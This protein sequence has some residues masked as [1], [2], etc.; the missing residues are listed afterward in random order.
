MKLGIR[1]KFIGILAIASLLPL[2]FAIVAVLTVG[3]SH[4]RK[5]RGVMFASAASYSART[6]R[7]LSQKQV[8]DI[9]DLIAL[10]DLHHMAEEVNQSHAA[11]ESVAV[12]ARMEAMEARWPKL[13]AHDPE[14]RRYLES[15]I[16]RSLR[17]FQAL[18]PV[19]KELFV[20]DALGGLTGTTAKTSDFVQ[21]DEKWW[22]EAAKLKTG[23]AWLDELHFDDSAGVF[24]LD[25]CV[26]IRPPEKL[27]GPISGVLKA[28]LN[29]SALF[30][31]VVTVGASEDM[32]TEVVLGDGHV[33][34]RML[35]RK[36]EPRAEKFAGATL[37]RIRDNR[38]GWLIGDLGTLGVQMVGFAPLKLNG[39]FS[40]DVSGSSAAQM[41]VTVRQPAGVVLAPVR[42]QV[43]L[44]TLAGIGLT[45]AFAFVGLFIARKHILEP[46]DVVKSAARTIAAGVRLAGETPADPGTTAGRF[47]GSSAAASVT[48]SL[49]SVRT[50]DELE[51]MARDF[52]R[53]ATKVLHYQDQ[54]EDDIAAKTREIQSDLA[55]ARE[56][57]EALLPRAYP[58]V[59]PEGEPDPVR[60]QFNHVYQPTLAMSGDFF[61]VIKVSDHKA[62][63]LIADVMGHGARSALVTAILRTLLQD[64]SAEA[65][66][67]ARML[68][69]LNQHFH[70]IIGRAK[71]VL[72]VSVSYIVID[73][74]SSEAVFA[75]AGHPSPLVANRNTGSVDP[76]FERLKNN[77]ALGLFPQ[78]HYTSMTRHVRP[79]DVFVLFTDGITEAP[80]ADGEE[81]GRER[82]MELISRNLNEDGAKFP[83][84]IVDG[85]H[86]FAGGTE[87]P[88]DVCLVTVEVMP[89]TNAESRERAFDS[90]EL[91]G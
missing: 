5:E 87:L 76:L 82:L 37:E 17:E 14:F 62:G 59:P 68:E 3:Y 46:L 84:R 48:Q 88:D 20:T 32:V 33:L 65:G 12:Q 9:N 36:F 28:V 52:G 39:V 66:D 31:Q 56:F 35:D 69:L 53:M 38:T 29:V 13:A 79:G 23:Q 22:Q 75:S 73:T 41:Y 11:E 67:P 24:S 49:Q 47:S 7:L 18:H 43:A 50:G 40:K 61:D 71:Q 6:L 72:Y 16:A 34:L 80:N 58:R 77:P 91:N 70:A 10:T 21:S 90:A 45:M 54:L 89:N 8:E 42:G 15:P 30:D 27:D 51:A 64:L 83:K 19:L 4:L 2:V 57:Q 60:L 78:A 55:M 74:Q 26:P 1:S 81:F 63:V 25:I 44:I 86:E 85:V